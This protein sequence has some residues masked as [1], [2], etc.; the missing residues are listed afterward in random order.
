VNRND[1]KGIARQEAVGRPSKDAAPQT[2][3][4]DK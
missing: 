4:E 2:E 1:P 3:G